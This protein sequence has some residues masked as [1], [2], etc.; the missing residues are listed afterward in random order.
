MQEETCRRRS[1]SGHRASRPTRRL[2]GVLRGQT[3][4]VRC[5]T[6]VA[7]GLKADSTQRVG[8]YRL[9][10]LRGRGAASEDEIETAVSL[11]QG[12]R[13]AAHLARQ[14]S[15]RSRDRGRRRQTAQSGLTT[16]DV[17]LDRSVN[18]LYETTR[19]RARMRSALYLSGCA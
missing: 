6:G 17:F 9:G 1:S 5:G 11:A 12:G 7:E 13:S 16:I 4:R 10:K 8:H 14:L 15:S 19:K 18:T 3:N 2:G